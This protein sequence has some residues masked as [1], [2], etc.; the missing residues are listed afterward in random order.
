MNYFHTEKLITA[1]V[2]LLDL[3]RVLDEQDHK[4]AALS[5]IMVVATATKP[6]KTL[7]ASRGDLEEPHDL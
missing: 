1:V 7:A 3:A 5:I 2:A 6:L 4:N